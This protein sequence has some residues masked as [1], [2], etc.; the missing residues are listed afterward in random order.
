MCKACLNVHVRL[1]ICLIALTGKSE[2]AA[3]PAA[4][5]QNGFRQSLE[6]RRCSFYVGGI[7]ASL[8]FCIFPFLSLLLEWNGFGMDFLLCWVLFVC[9]F[10]SFKKYFISTVV[11]E[12]HVH[13]CSEHSHTHSA[14]NG[15]PALGGPDWA[16][17]LD[18]V[19]SGGPCQ[20]RPICDS[21]NKCNCNESCELLEESIGSEALIPI[22]CLV[23]PWLPVVGQII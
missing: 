13:S 1:F 22:L 8:W 14:N 19:T 7:L 20:P 4:S 21:V 17:G 9:L 23:R 11:T 3:N 6:V 12:K 18:K 10:E 5:W 2:S 16:S 15:K